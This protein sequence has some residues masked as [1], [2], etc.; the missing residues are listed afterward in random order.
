MRR[1][2]ERSLRVESSACEGVEVGEREAAP[3]CAQDGE[4]CDAIGGMEQGAGER[5]EV[6]NLL[7]LGEGLDFDGAEGNGFYGARRRR[8]R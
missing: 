6:E 1:R 7:T 8:Y 2:S 5:G 4:G 3:G